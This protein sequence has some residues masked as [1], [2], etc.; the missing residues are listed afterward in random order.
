MA[1]TRGASVA[2]SDGG[3]LLDKYGKPM[4]TGRETFTQALQEVAAMDHL[5]PV[6][7]VPE[8]K[9]AFRSDASSWRRDMD[10]FEA[11]GLL[12]LIMGGLSIEMSPEDFMRVNADLRRHFRR[13]VVS[14]S[15]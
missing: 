3:E 8:Q 12:S 2:A 7:P 13:V 15:Q 14:D 11:L 1:R 10:G 6:I 9:F 4:P 5:A